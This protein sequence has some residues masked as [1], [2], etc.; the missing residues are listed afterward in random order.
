MALRLAS[1]PGTI[2]LPWPGVI[3]AAA[4]A[5]GGSSASGLAPEAMAGTDAPP[6]GSSHAV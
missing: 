4:P 3:A 6:Q 5:L 1:A 2:L